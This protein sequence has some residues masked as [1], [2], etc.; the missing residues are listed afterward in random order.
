MGELCEGGLVDKVV[1]CNLCFS[2]D[3]LLVVDG[4]DVEDTVESADQINLF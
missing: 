2:V 1:C 4:E 3:V